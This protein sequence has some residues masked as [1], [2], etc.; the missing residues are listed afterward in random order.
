MTPIRAEPIK[1]LSESPPDHT[2]FLVNAWCHRLT[3][4][5]NKKHLYACG[6]RILERSLE[7]KIAAAIPSPVP[8]PNIQRVVN[9]ATIRP[10]RLSQRRFELEENVN[11]LTSS[12]RCWHLRHNISIT[13]NDEDGD[14]VSNPTPN[15]VSWHCTFLQDNMPSYEKEVQILPA[16]KA[17]SRKEPL[18][19]GK[20]YLCNLLVRLRYCLDRNE[21]T[22]RRLSRWTKQQWQ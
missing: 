16:S 13:P 5:C 9:G 11:W 19:F 20:H 2:P 3:V 18:H 8:R 17:T 4:W 7:Q 14:K 6:A 22:L 12:F 15:P 1:R 21:C 10:A